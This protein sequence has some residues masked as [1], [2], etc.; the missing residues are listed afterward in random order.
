MTLAT[1]LP[2]RLAASGGWRDTSVE[3]PGSYVDVLTGRRWSETV[4]VNDLLGAY[5]VALLASE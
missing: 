3:F 1:R 2:I 4:A 5:P